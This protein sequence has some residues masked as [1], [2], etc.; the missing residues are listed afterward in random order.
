M[1]FRRLQTTEIHQFYRQ[2][3]FYKQFID[4]NEL[5]I[6]DPIMARETE[7]IKESYNFK[8]KSFIDALQWWTCQKGIILNNDW[9]WRNALTFVHRYMD[10]H[11]DTSTAVAFVLSSY[12]WKLLRLY[13]FK[14]T[15]PEILNNIPWGYDVVYGNMQLS[16]FCNDE[17]AFC[18]FLGQPGLLPPYANNQSADNYVSRVKTDPDLFGGVTGR[19]YATVEGRF[20]LTALGMET[21][22]G[23]VQDYLVKEHHVTQSSDLVESFLYDELN[24]ER[25]PVGFAYCVDSS[26]HLYSVDE[27]VQRYH[28]DKKAVRPLE[29]AG[30]K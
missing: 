5:A 26:E 2:D 27:V 3:S 14:H 13:V 18:N 12:T 28:H 20:R 1:S 9:L 23:P 21:T 17:A 19:Q 15:S 8:G 25:L 30:G 16:E 22:G 7:R 4:T 24:L 29:K 6:A 11:D 10:S